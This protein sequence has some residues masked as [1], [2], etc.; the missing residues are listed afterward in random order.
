[1][2]VA[3][4]APAGGLTSAVNGQRYEG[5]EFTPDH[6]KF[7]GKG[8]N[9]VGFAAFEAVAARVAAAGK[10]LSYD[11][12]HGRFL[13]KYPTGNVMMGAANLATLAR[14]F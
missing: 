11:E 1:M 4:R 3:N 7:C 6:G 10:V 2:N 14:C 9:R 12:A 8:K 5:G 13:V